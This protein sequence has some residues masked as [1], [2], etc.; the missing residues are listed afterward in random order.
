MNNVLIVDDHPIVRRGLKEILKDETDLA[1]TETSN[2]REAL[3][4]IKQQ[5]FDIVV[6]DLELPG[7]NG[8]ELLD[9][10]TR[11]HKRLRVL[12]LSIYPEDQFAVRVLKAGAAGF[13]SKEA[14]PEQLVVSIRKILSGRKHISDSTADRL[15]ERLRDRDVIQLHEKLSD[16]EFQILCRFGEGKTVK[17]IAEAL[18]L[19]APT[20]STY[21]ARILD[22]MDMRTTAQLVS[23]AIQNGL[24][25]PR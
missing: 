19:S 8:L 25:K 6:L 22:K 24:A 16:R 17:Q 15:A 2:A 18:S 21:R 23:Y 10:I 13:I 7:M 4:L 5:P 20:V 9:L 1:V 3:A 12:V 14:I 11:E